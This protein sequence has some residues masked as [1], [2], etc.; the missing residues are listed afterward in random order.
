MWEGGGSIRFYFSFAPLAL[1]VTGLYKTCRITMPQTIS[2]I[3][4]RVWANLRRCETVCK[5]RT[6]IITKSKRK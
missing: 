4:N 1:V 3:E 5:S 2:L 6:A